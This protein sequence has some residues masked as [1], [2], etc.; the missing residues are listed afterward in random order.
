MTLLSW[1]P[2]LSGLLLGWLL[3]GFCG[4]SLSFCVLSVGCIFVFF[5]FSFWSKVCFCLVLFVA[6]FISELF[7]IFFFFC[8]FHLGRLLR[9]G[10]IECCLLHIS[11]FPFATVSTDRIGEPFS[12][13]HF[14]HS[15][16]RRRLVGLLSLFVWLEISNSGI[17]TATSWGN[18][19]SA[20]FFEDLTGASWTM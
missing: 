11:Y 3:F 15:V 6:F 7:H 8:F 10:K 14:S 13:I 2:S 17:L 1:A 4:F 18:T 16:S 5:F 19:A 9:Q 12:L 20:S